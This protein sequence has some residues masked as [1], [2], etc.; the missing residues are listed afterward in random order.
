MLPEALVIFSCLKSVGCT[1]TSS[2]YYNTHPE[3]RE[4][5]NKNEQKIE[6]FVGPTAIQ[7]A[8]PVLYVL[9]GG[10]QTVR[11]TKSFSLQL[12][13]GRNI[14]IFSKEF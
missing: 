7:A 5:I 1:E 10:T 8:G 2:H 13:S 14:L 3:I 12:N 11:L 9:I 6:K 4:M